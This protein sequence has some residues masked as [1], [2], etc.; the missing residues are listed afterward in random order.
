MSTQPSLTS[1]WLLS[2]QISDISALNSLPN[3]TSLLLSD[4]QVSDISALTSLVNLTQLWLSSNQISDISAL[5]VLTSLTSLHLLFNQISD[6]SPLVA[7]QGI[8]TGDSV[9][10]R[11]NPL[12]QESRRTFIPQ[13]E[14]RG[15]NV[16][17]TSYSVT[18]PDA[19]LEAAIRTAVNKS[20]GTITSDDMKNLTSL[21]ASQ[22]GIQD[23]TGIEYANKLADLRL[24]SNQISDISPLVAN[25]GIS[26]GDLVDIQ[27]NPLSQESYDT[28]IPQ[29][30]ARGVDLRFTPS[31]AAVPALTPWALVG[32]TALLALLLMRR[33]RQRVSSPIWSRCSDARPRHSQVNLDQSHDRCFSYDQILRSGSERQCG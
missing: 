29:L 25:V 8:S 21:S 17:F 3:L 2:N 23:L 20:S 7:N 19:K 32:A 9:D 18:F 27:N 12:S 30:Q 10:I 16:Q 1:L 33:M 15:V 31:P 28:F 5:S 6:I 22:G 14:A 4:N 26:S 11:N 24:D 13:L